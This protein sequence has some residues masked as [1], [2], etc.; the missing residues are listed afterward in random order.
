M[1]LRGCWVQLPLQARED[2]IY[3]PGHVVGL[4]FPRGHEVRVF[5]TVVLH[6]VIPYQGQRFSFIHRVIGLVV[7]DIYVYLGADH[8]K[9]HTVPLQ[10]GPQRNL[11]RGETACCDDEDLVEV[12][13]AHVLDVGLTRDCSCACSWHV[14]QP[15]PWLVWEAIHLGPPGR[16]V[17]AHGSPA[18]C[19]RPDAA[20]LVDEEGL[21]H[22]RVAHDADVQRALDVLQP[23]RLRVAAPRL[24][25]QALLLPLGLQALLPRLDLRLTARQ[26]LPHRALRFALGRELPLHLGQGGRQL[27]QPRC[28]RRGHGRGRMRRPPRVPLS[29][30]LRKGLHQ[31]VLLRALLQ[32]LQPLLGCR[33]VE[34]QALQV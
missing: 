24:L 2:V 15:H 27:L 12:P 26:L 23:L 18:L 34:A 28:L 20:Q 14:P 16:L 22:A 6:E 33:P 3:Q 32:L 4:K 5:D 9:R 25:A 11:H 13:E 19:M 29:Q 8:E 10:L 7:P 1:K 30:L 21:A 31:K 17:D